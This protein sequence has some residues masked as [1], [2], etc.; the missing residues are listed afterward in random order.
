[1]PQKNIQIVHY[2]IHIE[3]G[4]N[5][6]L[7][8]YLLRRQ[9]THGVLRFGSQNVETGAYGWLASGGLGLNEAAIGTQMAIRAVL[10]ISMA[11]LYAPLE[12]YFGSTVRLCSEKGN[13]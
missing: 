13:A 12:R 2:R 8:P 1:M 9:D 6:L 10:H 4:G 11:A 5:N 7:K 3:A